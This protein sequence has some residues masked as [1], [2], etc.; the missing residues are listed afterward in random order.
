MR[1]G[2]QPPQRPPLA[3]AGTSNTAPRSPSASAPPRKQPWDPAFLSG[4][5]NAVAGDAI[6]FELAGGET[7][8]GT[9]RRAQSAEHSVIYV[10]GELTAPERGRF[11]F[12]KQTRPGRA[13]DYVGVVELPGVGRA[14][15]IEP[16]GPGG[17][18]ELVERPL[19]EVLCLQL[20]RPTKGG[21]NQTSDIPPLNPGSFP[22]L[23]IPGYQNGI[24][25]LESLH[26]ATAVLYMDFQGGYTPT[27]GGISYQPAGLDTNQIRALWEHVA[28]DFLPF[29]INV[30]TDVRVYQNAPEGSR[31][32]VIITPTNTAQPDAGGVAYVGSFN[33]TGDTPCWVFVTMVE[34]CAQACSH[35]LGH[36]LGLTHDGQQIGATHIEYFP[37]Q[38][39]AGVSWVP[40]MGVPY[41][42]M[43]VQ[44]CKGEYLYANNPDDQ[45]A[46]ISS[47]N[48]HV[49]YRT[50]DYTGG[51]L[52]TSRYLETYAD[53]TAGAQGLIEHTAGTNA[54]Q[55]T[56]QGGAVSL[57]ADPQSPAGPLALA[58]ALCDANNSVVLAS[59]PQ[60]TLGAALSTTNLPAGTYTFC[61]IGAGRNDPLTNGF[62]PY[63]SL[64]YYSITGSVANAR[65]PDRFSIPE[66]SPNQTVV[67]IVQASHPNGDPLLYSMVSGNTGNTFAIDNAGTLTVADNRLLDYPTLAAQT[68]LVVQFNLLV[69]ITDQQDPALTETNR[70]VVVA[71][72]PASTP[73]VILQQ[74]QSLSVVEGG[75]AAFSVTA[76]GDEPLSPLFYQWWFN[77]AALT[78]ATTPSLLL[79]AVQWQDSGGYFVTVSNALGVTTSATASLT[80]LA[81]PPSITAQPASEAVLPG[82]GA[83]FLVQAIGTPPLAYQWQFNGASLPAAT[84]PVL[85]LTSVQAAEVGSYQ[86]IVANPGG[87]ITS[88]PAALAIVPV[89]A[90]GWDEFGQT[91][92]SCQATDVVQISAG[93]YHNLALARDGQVIAWGSG[94]ATN[95]PAGLPEMVSV[96]AGGTH[97]LALSRDGSVFA[98][99]TNTYGQT[100]VPAGLSN[101]V[102]IAAGDS[103]SLALKSD[104][105]VAA[106]GLDSL[107]QA[108][109]PGWLTNIAAIAASADHSLALSGQG[110]VYAW[111][112]NLHGQTNVPPYL[113]GVVAIAAG[114]QH[115]LALLSDATVAAWGDNTY[116][117]TAVPAGLSNV[118]AVAAGA[119]HSLALRADGT[120]VGWGAWN[121]SLG[122]YPN[123]GQGVIPA[124][125]PPVT[126]IGAGTAHSLALVGE[127]APSITQPPVGQTVYRGTGA[128]FRTAASGA[129]PLAY[130]WRLNGTNLPGATSQVLVFT[131]AEQAGE[132]GVVVS[133]LLGVAV[134]A[135]VKLTLVEQA[136]SVVVQPRSQTGYLGGQVSLQVLAAGSGPMSYQWYA[137]GAAIPGATNATLT[138]AN[139][140]ENQSEDYY[141]VVSNPLG[142]VS[143]ATAS[144]NTAQVLAWGAGTN[145]SGNPNFGQSV[146]PPGLDGVVRLAGGGF[147]T[148]A[149][150]G[151]GTVLAWGAGTNISSDPNFGQ[152]M[153]PAGLSNVVAVAAGGY[154]S[155]ALKADGTI[156]AWG[157]GD[158]GETTVPVGLNNVVA[159][160]AGDFH[161]LALRGDGT[162]VVWG[163]NYTVNDVPSAA[164]GVVDIASAGANILGL[165]LDGT[166]VRWG[167]SATVPL[168]SDFVGVAAGSG[169]C[170]ALESSGTLV[171]LDTKDLPPDLPAVRAMAAGFLHNL[172]LERD[173][174][175]LAWGLLAGAL[176]MDQVPA[177]L[178]NVIDI[179]CGD[180]HNLAAV[181]APAPIIQAAPPD[182]AAE[183]G[184]STLF[185]VSA[186]GAQPLSFHWQFN[187]AN[188]PGAAVPRFELTGLQAA[189]AGGYRVIVSNAFGT[190]TSR[191]AQLSLLPSLAEAL[192][193]TGLVW[194]AAGDAGWWVETNVTHDGVAAAQSAHI[195][196]GQQASIWTFVT[197]PGTLSFWWKVSCAPG[198]GFLVFSADG[199]IQTN[200][201]GEVDWQQPG[202]SVPAGDHSLQWTYIQGTNASG[203][204]NAGWL[205]QVTYT[206]GNIK[207]PVIT[208]QPL[209]QT[210]PMGTNVVL[211]AAASGSSPISYQWFM[212]G[213]N[214]PG[215][216]STNLVLRTATRRTSGVYAL[217]ASNPAGSALSRNA[218]VL[219]LVPQ[220]LIL[221][222]RRSG[223]TFTLFS[224]DAD[225]GALLPSDLPA[226]Q[227]Q[228][229]ADLQVWTALP[230][231]LSITNG[232]LRLVDPAYTHY[233]R[234][235]YRL[236][237]HA[238]I[239]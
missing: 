187:G 90:W 183:L 229:S 186:A 236:C 60:D 230:N 92:V 172:A 1:S 137:N 107:G 113:Q 89:A 76:T 28:G 223:G 108:S 120:M 162:V 179:A 135:A 201:S 141:V 159:I 192:N 208:L 161:S 72:T 235:F 128:T 132:L 146:V 55:F 86:V 225:G 6:Q 32:R 188:L 10:S 97:S 178:T 181:G 167:N 219:V 58:V 88:S 111:G 20:P 153:V 83:S 45:L 15:R 59:N 232:L 145:W 40:I 82:S 238:S 105:T 154:H 68:T 91:N 33:W 160:A 220:K 138:L 233:A 17:S 21:T 75:S 112:D 67:G 122:L 194:S 31:Q 61:V 228:V 81:A 36:T 224:G 117:Q 13:G 125:L 193:G 54:F 41:Y 175:M 234:R 147:H 50:N 180:Y 214:L 70:R 174:T 12:Q 237:E 211:E 217:V 163:G 127:G 57:E 29:N 106:W 199:N 227:A 169:E 206:P 110:T 34:Y 101:V 56:T 177:G 213:T 25:S 69:D 26:G 142:T 35:E 166:L 96:A 190:V 8:V 215:A 155:L 205:D 231:S 24:I 62:S 93:A 204:L 148:L 150:K 22:Y 42:Q 124:H 99:G 168:G 202:F 144:V 191:V 116:G 30:T 51:T 222:P 104:G 18:P 16:S 27:W 218:S 65:V 100:Q 195:G 136:P 140:P 198:D 119:F 221:P 4:L 73:P 151:D 200:I 139:L 14:W 143:S 43:V 149:L 130:Q 239:P 203:W 126:A 48:N 71:V 197:G 171:S 78:N 210:V 156:A 53:G 207:P 9:I 196:D 184:G 52:A 63:A 121:T 11:F 157:L 38:G 182:R 5:S 49:A 79:P 164:I 44:W 152:S 47:G 185:S 123:L 39:I 98:W 23:P 131:Q 114:G 216:T 80:V 19:R 94:E 158:Y 85:A 173:G 95:V 103:H 46:M 87:S 84:N 170:L 165:K 133:N 2:S 3:S 189:D 176:G 7:V 118:V 134:S 74:P 209:S 66:H 109:V 37:G 212:D 77:G 129:L 102:A 115:C 226:F 64:G